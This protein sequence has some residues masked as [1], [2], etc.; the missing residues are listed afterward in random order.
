MQCHVRLDALSEN[1]FTALPERGPIVRDGC[2][3]PFSAPPAFAAPGPFFLQSFQKW[4]MQFDHSG[5]NQLSQVF[6]CDLGVLPV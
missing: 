6:V 5:S 1:C 4:I 3:I 2:P